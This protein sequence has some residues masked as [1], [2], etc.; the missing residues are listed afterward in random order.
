MKTREIITVISLL[1][2]VALTSWVW[3]SK[4]GMNHAPE[5][6]FKTIDGHQLELGALRGKPVLVTFWATTCIGCMREMPHLISLYNDLSPGME[7]IGVA[8]AYDPPSQVVK[9]AEIK[10]IPYPISLDIDG[11]IASAFGDVMLTP[12]SF[13]ISPDGKIIRHKVGE[14]DMDKLHNQLVDIIA[15]EKLVSTNILKDNNS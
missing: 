8:M 3:I 7:I 10:Q 2:L 6:T 14:M 4:S 12:T 9:L 5:V 1:I 13:L 15:T 11:K